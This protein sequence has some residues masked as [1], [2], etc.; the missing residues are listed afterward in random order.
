MG[1][2]TVSFYIDENLDKRMDDIAI[3]KSKLVD[4]LLRKWAGW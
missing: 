3:N 2:K 1:K 4:K